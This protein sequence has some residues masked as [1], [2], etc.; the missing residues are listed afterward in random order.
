MDVHLRQLRHLTS[1]AE[2][3]SYT[4][5]AAA[6]GLS[7]PSLSRS[8]QALERNLGARLF[9]LTRTGVV[10]TAVGQLVIDRTRRVLRE[11]RDLEREV[12]LALALETGRIRVGV[13]P[14]P[15]EISVGTAAGRLTGRRPGVQV[16]L[17][18]SHW[19]NL[20]ESV[21]DGELDLAIGETSA[22]RGNPRLIVEALKPHRGRFFCRPGHPLARQRRVSLDDLRA[23]PCS[24][25]ILPDRFPLA[26]SAIRADT[27]Q[28][29][30]SVVLESD[31]VG[32]AIPT[33]IEAELR[34]GGLVLLSFEAP[35][36]MTNYGFI[37]LA[38]RTPSP[39]ALAMID[40]VREVEDEIRA[41]PAAG[42]AV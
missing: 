1:L 23:Y 7:Q 20:T 39:A 26:A 27:F 8:I 2:H 15:A 29:A 3:G 5:A 24:S 14:Y 32:L 6:T 34:D 4:R 10:P 13:G 31:A 33:M 41:R 42:P 19:A 12:S 22:A 16:E 17:V 40:T 37:R 18:V 35:W 28:L 25:P 21:L 38:D 11:A 36:L 9:D 30:K